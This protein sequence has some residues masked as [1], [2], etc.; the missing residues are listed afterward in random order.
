MS[1]LPEESRIAFRTIIDLTYY[2]QEKWNRSS[3]ELLMRSGINFDLLAAKGI[4]H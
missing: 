2:R 3:I 1:N 4:S